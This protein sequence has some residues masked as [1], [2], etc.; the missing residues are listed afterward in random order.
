MLRTI[1]GMLFGVMNAWLALP[2]LEE[3]MIETQAL[4]TAKLA[5]ADKH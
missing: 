4:I 1:T 3:S 5:G 2:Y